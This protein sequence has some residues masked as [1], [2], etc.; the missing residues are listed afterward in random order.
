MWRREDP[1]AG[2]L[3][4]TLLSLAAWRARAALVETVKWAEDDDALIVRLF[5]PDGGSGL[6]SLRLGVAPRAVDEVDLLERNARPLPIAED[7]AVA[8]TLRAHEIETL[9]IFA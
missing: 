6:A 1:H 2:R 7:H 4:L 3:P 9:R 8:L 5:E